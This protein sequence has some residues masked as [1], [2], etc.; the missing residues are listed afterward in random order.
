MRTFLG[1]Y[2]RYAAATVAAAATDARTAA[3]VHLSAVRTAQR[4]RREHAQLETDSATS[5]AALRE[6]GE[7]IDELEA[8]IS[9]IKESKA[10]AAARDLDDREK[11]VEA[12]GSSA[13]TAQLP[14][15]RPPNPEARTVSCEPP[16]NSART[17]GR[18]ASSVRTWM[19]PP[20]ASAP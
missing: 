3:E 12:L 20:S 1:T 4:L 7:Q 2:R 13:D 15:R 17:R 6:L 18:C 5:G 19:T 9:G 10:Y 11:R 16:S 8:T 14:K